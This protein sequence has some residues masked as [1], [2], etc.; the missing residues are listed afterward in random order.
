MLQ[1]CGQASLEVAEMGISKME[2]WSVEVE[3]AGSTDLEA[4]Q[5]YA[6]NYVR[7]F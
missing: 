4:T 3:V 5:I 2:F 6:E 7:I 1:G